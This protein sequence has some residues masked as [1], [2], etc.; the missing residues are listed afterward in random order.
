MYNNTCIAQEIPTC[1][2]NLTNPNLLLTKHIPDSIKTPVKTIT[3]SFHVWRNNDSTGNYWQDLQAY[4]DT[5][6]TI[7]NSLSDVC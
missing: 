1:G 2:F 6:R 4:R 5:L 3:I 7:V